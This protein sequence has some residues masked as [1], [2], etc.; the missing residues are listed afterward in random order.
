[1][2]FLDISEQPTFWIDLD[3]GVVN[4]EC[5]WLQCENDAEDDLLW[6]AVAISNSTFIEAFY[7]HRFNNK[8]Y[9]GRRRFITQYVE[10]FPLLDPQKDKSQEIVKTV[11][12]IYASLPSPESDSLIKNLNEKIWNAFGLNVEKVSR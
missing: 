1:M 3:G 9:A 4:G 8:L 2:V 12:K 11:K 7:D 10:Q 6:L 5:Y